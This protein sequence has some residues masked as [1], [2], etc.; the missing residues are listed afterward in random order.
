[1]TMIAGNRLI[2][3]RHAMP[4]VDPAVP[5]GQWHLGAGGRAAARALRPLVSGPAD[6][7]A[8]TEP[9]AQQTLQELAG[10]PVVE[11]DAR[12]A[13]VRRPRVWSDGDSYRA[14]AHDYVR[15]RRLDGWEPHEDVV[16]R[17]EAAV[18]HH[19]AT[20]AARGRTLV[21]GTHGLA[22][23]LWLAGRFP[24]AP[25]PAGFWQSL[26][27][28]ELIDIDLRTGE[29]TRREPSWCPDGAPV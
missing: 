28:P 15:G 14:R 24:L 8:S 5:A 17:F 16:A 7:V 21:V 22:A 4:E 23:T 10:R 6:H 29:L 11:A 25:D 19:A 1:M 26:R 27:F 2:L 13:E 12:F 3:I 9:K 18:V 20:A